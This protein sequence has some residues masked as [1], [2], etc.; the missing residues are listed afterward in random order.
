MG[1]DF[2]V[3]LHGYKAICPALGVADR[4][5]AKKILKEKG[6][7]HIVAAALRNTTGVVENTYEYLRTGATKRMIDGK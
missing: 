5:T 2:E 4:R 6:L 7:L 3:P 1:F